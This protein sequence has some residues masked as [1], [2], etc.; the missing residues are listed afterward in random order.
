MSVVFLIKEALQQAKER[1]QEA[2]ELEPTR[3]HIDATIQ[4]FEFT[5]ELSW[6]AIQRSLHDQGI[7]CASPRE[8]FRLAADTSLINDPEEWF[9]FLKYRNL[10]TH[11]YNEEVAKEV[12]AGIHGF[13]GFVDA[14][15][16]KMD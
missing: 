1:L 8:C 4:R 12:Y 7:D 11:T 15:L 9:S 16:S 3:I 14:L 13:P 5:F 2:L 6:K 10:T